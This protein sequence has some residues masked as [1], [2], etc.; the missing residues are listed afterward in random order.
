M[1]DQITQKSVAR[2]LDRAAEHP[3]SSKQ[4]GCGGRLGRQGQEKT[5][6]TYTVFDANDS[7]RIYGRSLTAF[8]AMSKILTYDGY[9]YEIRKSDF[10]GS[11]CWD[12]YHSDGSV[13]STRG[14]DHM[15]KTVIFSL[16]GDEAHA[17]QEIAE[18]V[19]AA[20]WDGL[21]EV[22]TDEDFDAML[23]EIAADEA[24]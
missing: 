5:M 11:V 6:T 4:V 17:E 19:I 8:E 12:L 22:M 20:G 14:A 9:R 16:I 18:H 1:E 15:V 21:P 7:S 13:Y 3:A 23:A 24:E 10:Q 2:I